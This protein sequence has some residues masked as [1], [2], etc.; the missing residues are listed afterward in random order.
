M[1]KS[2]LVLGPLVLGLLVLGLL[3]WSLKVVPVA[4]ATPPQ[5]VAITTSKP[6]G[7]FPG[8]WSAVGVV[9]DAGTFHTLKLDVSASG[10]PAFQITHVT[11]EFASPRGTFT[12]QAQITETLTADPDVLTDAGTW[13][14]SGETGA[15]ATLHGQGQVVGTVDEHTHLVTRTYSGDAHFD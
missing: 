11:Y 12:L 10:A 6:T 13:V 14:I 15:Y 4:S 3:L 8:T 5:A 1:R 9:S 7:P 2:A